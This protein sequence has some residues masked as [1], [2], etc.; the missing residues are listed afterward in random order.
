[1][2]GDSSAV[3]DHFAHER[4]CEVGR[5]PPT[6]IPAGAAAQVG[7]LVIVPMQPQDPNLPNVV[8]SPGVIPVGAFPD[9]LIVRVD[10]ASPL[11]L[12]GLRVGFR[13]HGAATGEMMLQPENHRP[14][15]N[16]SRTLVREVIRNGTRVA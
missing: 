8:V 15:P 3:A 10:Q 7:D 4:S 13:Y 9:E 6:P 11:E 2:L 1:M 14:T 16:F 5:G 12:Q